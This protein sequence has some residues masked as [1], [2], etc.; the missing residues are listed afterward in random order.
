MLEVGGK[1]ILETIVRRFVDSGFT[2]ITMCLGYK[3]NVIQDHFQDGGGFGANIDYIVEEKRMGTAGALTLLGKFFN[4][5]FFIYEWR[6]A[7][8]C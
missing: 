1:P 5:S 7:H 2:N 8:Q 3:S 4:K 6:F